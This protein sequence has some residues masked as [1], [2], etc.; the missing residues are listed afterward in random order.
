M[1]S[2][3]CFKNILECPWCNDSVE[4]SLELYA[5]NHGAKTRKCEKCGFV[6]SDRILN[7]KGLQV[8]WDKY[9]SKVHNQT[10]EMQNQRDKMY[11]VE[12][13]YIDNLVGVTGKKVLDVGCAAGGFL[14]LFH[15]KG[16]Q[17]F[18]T[19]IGREAAELAAKKYKVFMGDLSELITEERF[20]III[21]RGVIQYFINPKECFAKATSLLNDGG[22]LY[23]TSSPNS[24]SLCFNLFKEQF[25]L[26]VGVCDYW[27]YSEKLLTKFL[28]ELGMHLFTTKYFYEETPY[29][30]VKEDILKVANAITLVEEGKKPEYKSPLFYDNM[31]TLIYVYRGDIYYEY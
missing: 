11:R 10:A 13:E 18:G 28:K 12:F 16:A 3:D 2:E 22:I 17:C 7:K 14:D 24:E 9:E 19:E 25:R 1:L 26:P 27:A 20:D 5:T 29:A 31:L 30:N 21:F 15:A 4:R 23:I 8:F 6:Y